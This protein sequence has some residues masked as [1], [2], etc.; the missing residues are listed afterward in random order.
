MQITSIDPNKLSSAIKQFYDIKIKHLDKIVFFQMG[1]FYEMFFEDAIYM[2]NTCDLALTT[3][4]AGLEERI[5]MAG[6]PLNQLNE[7]VKMVLEDNHKVVLVQQGE[8]GDNKIMTRNIT[9]IFSS[10]NFLEDGS[11]NRYVG[12]FYEHQHN[13]YL[14]YGDITTGSMYHTSSDDYYLLINEINTNNILEIININDSIKN[15]KDIDEKIEIINVVNMDVVSK[16]I[17]VVDNEL[18]KYIKEINCGCV[19]HLQQFEYVNLE[20]TL[21]MNAY[22]QKAL[23]LTTNLYDNDEATLFYYLNHTHTAM[24]KRLLKNNIINPLVNQEKINY[25]LD[26][27]DFFLNNQLL[28]NQVIDYLKGIY[29][30]ERIVARISDNTILPK[31]I[32]QLKT[33]LINIKKIYDVMKHSD[34]KMLDKITSL[35]DVAK[36]I[37]YLDTMIL[38]E[39]NLTLKEGNVINH[40]VNEELDELRMLK[41]NSNQ[42][43]KDYE[44]EQKNLTGCKNLKVK[45]NRVFGHYIE[46]P[47]GSLDCVLDNY[48]EKQT[49][50]NAKRFV[51]TE[52]QDVEQKLL[53]ANDKIVKIESEIFDEVK[54]FIHKEISNIIHYAKV[55]SEIDFYQ[56]LAYVAT[57]DMLTRPVFNNEDKFIIKDGFHPVIKKLVDNYIVNDTVLDNDKN[58]MLITGP[59]MSGKSTY[60]RQ[61]ALIVIMAQLGSYIPASSANLSIVDK[62]FTRIGA[63]DDSFKG[64]STFM[65]EMEESSVALSQATK[66]SLI[67]FDELG[68]G[69]STYDGM[70]LAASILEYI[71]NEVGC[72]TMF[73]THYHELIDLENSLDKLFNVH[74]KAV[75]ENG[76][77]TFMHKVIDGGVEKSYGILVAKLAKLPTEVI[78]R[79]NDYLNYFMSNNKSSDKIEVIETKTDKRLEKL[80]IMLH[81]VDPLDVTPREALDLLIDIKEIIKEEND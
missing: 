81:Q 57:K 53:T 35:S 71:N 49:L 73:S 67:L 23:E 56:T 41:N 22:T 45:Y 79:A 44:E 5:P 33:S 1:D 69:T 6:I 75:E 3:K 55:I 78:I 21:I 29:D 20:D 54:N 9:K 14:A 17:E 48:V 50:A 61:T 18:I 32:I 63:S 58:I 70:S 80:E 39:P 51:T 66:D 60:M 34:I 64:N 38:E 76:H 13:Y 15:V 27:V 7:Y 43:F 12:A 8:I 2:A 19:D 16:G 25:R 62:I 52:L 30:I 65:V 10:S 74:V 59:N 37:E 77:I 72:K 36:I 31:D 40:N 28:H 68:R 42:W 4:G 47:N 11:D 46:I 24:G 26:N